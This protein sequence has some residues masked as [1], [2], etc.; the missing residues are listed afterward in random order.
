MVREP[1]LIMAAAAEI[2]HEGQ[3]VDIR[4]DVSKSGC[5]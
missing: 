5:M 3:F 1:F 2:R 4:C